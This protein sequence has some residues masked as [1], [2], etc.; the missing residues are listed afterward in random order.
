[1]VGRALSRSRTAA[2]TATTKGAADGLDSVESANLAELPSSGASPSLSY[3]GEHVFL[4]SHPGVFSEGVHV[5]SATGHHHTRPRSWELEHRPAVAVSDLQANRERL[6][7][8]Q[9]PDSSSQGG[10]HPALARSQHLDLVA[11]HSQRNLDNLTNPVFFTSPFRRG[12]ASSP[13]STSMAVQSAA[14]GHVSGGSSQIRQFQLNLVSESSVL[15]TYAEL[16]H[17]RGDLGPLVAARTHASD[18]SLSDLVAPQLGP[19]P[20]PLPSIYW[21]LFDVEHDSVDW[22]K[23]VSRSPPSKALSGD[24]GSMTAPHVAVTPTP[25]SFL[26]KW[27]DMLT[28]ERQIRSSHDA[29][30]PPQSRQAQTQTQTQVQ[31]QTVEAKRASC[32]VSPTISGMIGF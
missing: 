21:F 15:P 4:S 22:H 9:H 23:G 26:A 6:V 13:G 2:A 12:G 17:P 14:G 31:A 28:L 32:E 19:S 3:A 5:E 1:M 16:G 24:A 10:T 8:Y 20:T 7:S 25:I 29:N 30:V 18:L 11:G 27:E